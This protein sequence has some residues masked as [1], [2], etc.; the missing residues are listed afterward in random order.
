PPLLP[1]YDVRVSPL[2]GLS[3]EPHKDCVPY[4][5][6]LCSHSHGARGK[7]GLLRCRRRTQAKHRWDQSRAKGGWLPYYL[8]VEFLPGRGRKDLPRVPS[9]HL[10]LRFR[11]TLR[12]QGVSLVA[13]VAPITLIR[14]WPP[15]ASMQR[16]A[17]SRFRWSGT[18]DGGYTT[19]LLLS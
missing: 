11:L 16:G 8:S 13:L 10:V 19:S 17:F 9:Q 7:F 1:C 5:R 18:Y 14:S 4:R 12:P 3:Y 15:R 2:G 6:R